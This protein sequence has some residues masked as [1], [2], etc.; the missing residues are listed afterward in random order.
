MRGVQVLFWDTRKLQEPVDIFC[1]D[2]Q[3]KQ[4]CT[5]TTGAMC[6]EYEP[7][8]VAV[9]LITATLHITC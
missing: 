9:V 3:K 6:L 8:M 5:R 1:L 4:D 2:A 7:A